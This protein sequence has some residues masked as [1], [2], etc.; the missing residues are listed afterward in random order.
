MPEERFVPIKG[1]EGRYWISD[2]GR[3]VSYDQRKNTVNFLSTYI[4]VLGYAA[5]TLRMKPKKRK[6]RTHVLVAEHFLEKASADQTHVNHK[7]GFK[8]WNYYKDL[9]WCTPARNLSHAVETG[10][11]NLK[12][13]RHP[14]GK[15]KEQQVKQIRSLYLTGM[16]QQEIADKFGICRRQAGDIINRKNWGWLN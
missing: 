10:L 11:H 8:F 12:G 15:L 7:T 1:F 2:F 14:N 9:E 4:D 16:T 5:P 3:I 6:A 13:E